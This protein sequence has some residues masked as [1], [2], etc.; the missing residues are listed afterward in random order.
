MSLAHETAGMEKNHYDDP[1]PV[2]YSLAD[3]A[4]GHQLSSND[5]DAVIVV[6]DQNELKRDLKGRHMQMIAM[7]VS[8]RTP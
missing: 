8:P 4:K 6:S 7:S 2:H 5:E 1:P 3:P